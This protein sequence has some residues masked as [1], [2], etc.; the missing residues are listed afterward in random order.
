M[1][2][3]PGFSFQ[4]GFRVL[5]L[6]LLLQATGQAAN[7]LV[8]V[9]LDEVDIEASEILSESERSSLVAAFLGS[10]IDA[11]LIRTILSEISNDFINRGYVTSRPYL[12]EQDISDGRIEIRV[13]VGRIEA[14]VDAD[15]GE[16]N[17][18]IATAF[19]FHD[20]ILNLR[21]LETSLEV[22]E[23]PDS[24]SAG[25]EIKPGA[26]QGGSLVEIRTIESSRFHLELGVNAQTDLDSQMSFQAVLDNPLNI[27]D[28]VEIRYNSREAY[29]D[30]QNNRSREFSYSFPLASYLFALNYS[31]I[32]YNQRIQGISDSFVSEGDTITKELLISKLLTRSQTGKLALAVG[33]ELK[34]SDVYF[35]RERIDVSSYKTSQLRLELRHDWL[36]LWGQLSTV[37]SYHQG[38]DAFGAR[39]D[40]YFRNI[41]GQDSEARLQFEKYNID[42]Q[43][44]Y[45]LTNPAWY[46]VLGFHLQYSDDILYDN[47]KLY[48]GSPYTVRG[49]SS[50]LSGSNAWYLRSD[51]ARRLQSVVNPFSGN[52]L[53]KSI[54]VSA[55]LDYGEV[56]CEVDNSDVCGEIYGLALGLEI[57]DANFNGR[58]QL[59]YPLKEIGEDIGD[60]NTY[61]LDLRWAL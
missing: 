19:I 39:D 54:S 61:M 37:Y 9:V 33:L 30:Y 13:L 1:P 12:L 28:I 59:G 35:E 11:D 45:Y 10:C 38:L 3:L 21:D 40:D 56:K 17:G 4:S 51:L 31:D 8:C 42:S 36:P 48:L 32:E 41:A 34:D 46:A 52:P 6:S 25:F 57:A 2:R 55:G 7:D 50:A 18:K 24:V 43:L 60:Q 29:Q 44:I 22:I 14:I 58:L 5:G 23:R 15:S 27:N 16:S 53:I 49:Y 47:D 26:Q 20:E